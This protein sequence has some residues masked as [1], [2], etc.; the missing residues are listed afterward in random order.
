MSRRAGIGTTEEGLA[1]GLAEAMATADLDGIVE[2]GA[3]VLVKPNLHGGSGY[4]S[5]QAIEATVNWLRDMG[6]GK[7]VVGEGPYYGLDNPWPY[8]SEI[9]ATGLCRRLGVKLVNFHEHDYTLVRSNMPALPESIGI[10]RWVEWA[11]VVVSL[12]VMKTHFN[13]LTTLSIKN[14]K[15][16][17]RRQDKRDIHRMDLHLAIAALARLIRP[18]I[19]IIDASVAYE[20]MGPSNATPVPMNLVIAA[21][22]AF[23]ADVIANWLMGFEPARVRYLREAERLGLGQIPADDEGVAGLC[24]V[25]VARMRALRR[26]FEAPYEAAARDYPNLRISTDLACSGCVMNLFTALKELRE[27]GKAGRLRGTVAVGKPPQALDLAVGNCT[28]AAWDDAPHV[29]GCPP[30]IEDIKAAL[31]QLGRCDGPGED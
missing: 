1:A 9:G 24:N 25:P 20:G 27:A 13:T 21:S 5:M 15:G 18:H 29:E 4:T 23:D 17:I 26:R 11:D 10:T 8:F 28:F 6:A 7:V 12:A 30:H 16:F 3:N 2:L 19:N 14:L 22:A 31:E